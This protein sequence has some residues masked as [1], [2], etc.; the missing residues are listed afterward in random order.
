V[1]PNDGRSPGVTVVRKSGGEEE[2]GTI[3]AIVGPFMMF[4]TEIG[5]G[6]YMSRGIPMDDIADLYVLE[7]ESKIEKPEV[8]LVDPST[9][10]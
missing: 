3:G 2:F 9:V 1:E 10:S 8:R 4:L 7:Y 5:D 6:W